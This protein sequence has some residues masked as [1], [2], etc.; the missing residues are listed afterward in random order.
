[1][2]LQVDWAGQS[3]VKAATSELLEQAVSCRAAW[4]VALAGRG[5]AGRPGFEKQQGPELPFSYEEVCTHLE[6][7]LLMNAWSSQIAGSIRLPEGK[8]YPRVRNVQVSW[9]E[10]H[11]NLKTFK[12]FNQPSG[13][14]PGFRLIE[15]DCSHRR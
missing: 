7:D 8:V 10:Q 14:S 6:K 12:A 13:L 2:P 9:F 4:L 11:L 3:P 1:M 15:A 5:C